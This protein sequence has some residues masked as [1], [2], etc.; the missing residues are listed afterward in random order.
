MRDGGVAWA[1]LGTSASGD[2]RQQQFPHRSWPRE[3]RV[4]TD[5]NEPLAH[6]RASRA[7]A[8]RK[9]RRPDPLSSVDELGTS[10]T[11]RVGESE[12]A[13]ASC[14]R[15]AT[16]ARARSAAS[17]RRACS[18]AAARRL[19]ARRERAVDRSP[20]AVVLGTAR[21]GEEVVG[22]AGVGGVGVDEVGAE[23]DVVGVEVVGAGCVGLAET[24]PAPGAGS[25]A[26]CVGCGAP[27]GSGAAAA[28]DGGPRHASRTQS[29]RN[30]AR[31]QG[32]AA[33][34]VRGTPLLGAA[35]SKC[36][37]PPRS[38]DASPT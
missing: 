18:R 14:R 7:Q 13:A 32:A 16:R 6:S 15:A 5:R 27:S 25:G 24:P 33:R 1:A 31:R 11:S 26:G 38:G 28:A 10:A 37:H 17:T 12:S 34:A 21:V 19:A 8:A 9:S 4:A 22:C 36:F 23:G 35:G 2:Q 3:I 30:G 20:D 29:R